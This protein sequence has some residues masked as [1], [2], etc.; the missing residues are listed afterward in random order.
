MLMLRSLDNRE[1]RSV[2]LVSYEEDTEK[3]SS[4]GKS[5]KLEDPLYSDIRSVLTID[6]FYA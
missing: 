1:S 5:I 6:N 3:M 2:C 4:F